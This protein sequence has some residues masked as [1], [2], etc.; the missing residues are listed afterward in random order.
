MVETNVPET[1]AVGAEGE[2]Y[3]SPPIHTKSWYNVGLSLDID[4]RHCF[5]SSQMTNTLLS[6][7]TVECRPDV[8][9]T[10]RRAKMRSEVF[11]HETPP[12]PLQIE[13]LSYGVDALQPGQDDVYSVTRMTP[14]TSLTTTYETDISDPREKYAQESISPQ[15]GKN[16]SAGNVS[17]VHSYFTIEII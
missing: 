2:V 7:A 8:L 12:H 17:L 10:L 3:Q 1:S 14:R 16:Q 15:V 4:Q 13:E 5:S 11:D 6:R 9:R